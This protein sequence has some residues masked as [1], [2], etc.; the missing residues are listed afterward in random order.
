MAVECARVE[1]AI[2]I[3]GKKTERGPEYAIDLVILYRFGLPGDA[4]K[5][6]QS[7]LR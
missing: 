4:G 5:A 7:S 3:K 2:V 6:T 1:A